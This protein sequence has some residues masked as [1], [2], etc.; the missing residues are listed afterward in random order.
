MR[1]VGIFGSTF[2][3]VVIIAAVIQGLGARAHSDTAATAASGFVGSWRVTV[4]NSDGSTFPVLSSYMADGTT[5]HDGPISQPA[6][7][8]SP[9]A[10]RFQSAG[11]GV[12]E[13]TGAETSTVTFEVLTGDERGDFLGRVTV[14]G[15]QT[16]DPSGVSFTGRYVITITDPGGNVVATVPTTAKGERMQIEV[17]TFPGTPEAAT[18]AA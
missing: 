13:A 11:N 14:S 6:A 10:V 4:T 12:W 2:V 15:V 9:Y 3:A 18:P 1:R 16:L 17:P 7:P 5:V 8:G